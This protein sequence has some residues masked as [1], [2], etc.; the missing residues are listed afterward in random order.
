MKL[1]PLRI[2]KIVILCLFAAAGNFLLNTLVET[3]LHLPLFLD[4]LFTVALTFAAGPLPGIATA[5][6]T[7]LAKWLRYERMYEKVWTYLFVLCSIAEVIIVWLFNRRYLKTHTDMDIPGEKYPYG[8]ITKAVFLLKLFLVACVAIS[9][10]GGIIDLLANPAT[11]GYFSPEDTFKMSLLRYGTP[12]LEANILSRIPINI[13]DRFIVIFGGYAV[14]L[15][16]VPFL[17]NKKNPKPNPI[18]PPAPAGS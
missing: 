16:A 18:T 8:I 13:V 4:T 15:L 7:S 9:V 2:G 6:L 10:S 11:K 12:L 17:N 14:S 5:I 1:N 3:V